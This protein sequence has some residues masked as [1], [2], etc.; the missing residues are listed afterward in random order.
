MERAVPYAALVR[1]AAEMH[2]L[3]LRLA[4][5]LGAGDL[6]LAIGPLGAGKT[7]L[8][9]GIAQ[10]L[11]VRGAVTSPTF[12]LARE[13]GAAKGGVPLVHVD[14]YRL[15]NVADPLGEI[16]ALDLDATL[17]GA[18]TVVE[19]GEGL[20]ERLAANRVEVRIELSGDGR[21]VIVDPLGPQWS[22]ADVRSVL[23]GS[24]A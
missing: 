22:D 2:E 20:V 18:V 12:V 15:G 14:A 1:S 13:H 3:G 9:Q 8:T 19:W 5:V 21:Y 4:S 17:E 24:E 7:T 10:G 6:V 16:D 11:R 23:A